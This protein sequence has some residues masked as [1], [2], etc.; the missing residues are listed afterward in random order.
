MTDGRTA[1]YAHS[2]EAACALVETHVREML[3]FRFRL[4]VKV[5]IPMMA[6]PQGLQI[7]AS[8]YLFAIAFDSSATIAIDNTQSSQTY[9]LTTTG[10][11][12]L[13]VVAAWV[14]TGDHSLSSITYNGSTLTAT[15][16]QQGYLNTDTV[17]M[18]HLIAPSTGANNVVQTYSGTGYAA[19]A[20]TSYTGMKQ[21]GQPDATT[22]DAGDGAS[23]NFSLTL[24]TVADNCWMVGAWQ[25]A[26]G[27]CSAGSNT[28]IRAT[29]T[30]QIGDN[31]VAQTPAGSHSLNMVSCGN[32]VQAKVVASFAPNT[33]TDYTITAALGTYTYTGIAA[34]FH[35]ALNMLAAVGT[36]TLTGIDA[37]LSK[38][39]GF[40]ANVGTFVLTGID[41]NFTKAL[42]MVAAV[43]TFTLT[44]IDALFNYGRSMIA[45]VG[46]FILS[47]KTVRVPLILT[48][49]AKHSATLSGQS[50][51]AVTLTLEDQSNVG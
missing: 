20:A 23:N 7:P 37:V 19:G 13:L 42:N 1:Q 33:S 6:T 28:A 29:T 38:G 15:V 8:P 3:A 18:R 21:S 47:F 22:S 9:A 36:Y 11:N 12:R 45:S 39:F 50:K 5:W 16:N 35:L 17:Y 32:R 51:N 46:S 4:P 24:T 49:E 41:S 10:S 31:G 30:D 27:T 43:G 34:L 40:A 25:P 48:K 44:G 2:F 14:R 26:D